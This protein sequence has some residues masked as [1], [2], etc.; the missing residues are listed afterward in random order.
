MM[1]TVAFTDCT[2]A[3]NMS[4]KGF[5]GIMYWSPPPTPSLLPRDGGAWW[6]T[7]PVMLPFPPPLALHE[8]SRFL[9]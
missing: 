9:D 5:V 4:Y 1:K 2:K 3:F 7:T 8:V 6:G